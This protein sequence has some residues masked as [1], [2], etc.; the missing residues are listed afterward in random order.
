MTDAI[1]LAGGRDPDL[2]AGI[3]N[4]AFIQIDGRPLVAFVVEALRGS[5]GIGQI[6]VAG[7]STEL[8]Q[9]FPS[10][11]LIVPDQNTIMEN[12]LAA[13]RSLGSST[14]TLVVG[15]DIP[16]LT[17]RVI[18]EFLS[19][20]AQTPA[21][22]YYP[23]VPQVEM[24]TRF[25]GVRKTYVRVI[26]GA[27]CGGSVLFLN[28]EVLVRLRP[29]VERILAARKQPWVL[30]QI[31]GWSIVLKLAAGR[32]SIDE[33]VGKT[34]ELT[35]LTVKPVIVPLPELALDVDSGKP[36]NLQLIQAA[37]GSRHPVP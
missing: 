10:G 4:K 34:T 27:L 14:P 26:E 5:R 21:D 25:P 29:F 8:S 23:V 35:G 36:E 32:L 11:I 13:T 17:G 33:L 37:L 1:V 12:I 7:P 3:P 28:P 30:A 24:E 6:A 2:E 20:C 22:V 31:F 19:I 9:C 18:E 16:L 15:A